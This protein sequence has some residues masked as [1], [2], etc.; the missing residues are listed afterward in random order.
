[1]EFIAASATSL[2]LANSSADLFLSFWGLHCFDDPAAAIAEAGRV[3]AP[4]GRLVG[5]TFVRGDKSLRQRLLVRPGAGDFGCV[6][7]ADEVEGCLGSA[8]LAVEIR[9]CGPM[10]YFD[11]SIVAESPGG[12]SRLAGVHD[13]P[14][15]DGERGP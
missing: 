15:A 2:P 14:R 5:A 3:L 10:L 8:G 13:P 9:R 1:M 12:D 4:G 11:A 6:P 7:T